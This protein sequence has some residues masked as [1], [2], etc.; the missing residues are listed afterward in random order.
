MIA[1]FEEQEHQYKQLIY[2]SDDLGSFLQTK[3]ASKLLWIFVPTGN[4]MSCQI[5]DF[6]QLRKYIRSELSKTVAFDVRHGQLHASMLVTSI[7]HVNQIL[8]NNNFIPL[9]L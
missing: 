5:C 8:K 9:L 7:A 3:E 2:S 1:P 6:E 4:S